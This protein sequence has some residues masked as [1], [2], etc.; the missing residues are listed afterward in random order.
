MID[1]AGRAAET[2][3]AGGIGA[4]NLEALE[5]IP[6]STKGSSEIKSALHGRMIVVPDDTLPPPLRNRLH[7]D[8]DPQHPR[9]WTRRAAR[10]EV[11]TEDTDDGPVERKGVRYV[12][13]PIH[14]IAFA[15]PTSFA[16]HRVHCAAF[17]GDADSP[18][19]G[20]RGGWGGDEE[21]DDSEDLHHADLAIRQV[22]AHLLVGDEVAEVCV[23]RFFDSNRDPIALFL[24]PRMLARAVTLQLEG[25]EDEDERAAFFDLVQD[26]LDDILSAGHCYRGDDD[27][28]PIPS[29]YR[30]LHA[31][32][33]VSDRLRD[34]KSN[35]FSIA[36]CVELLADEQAA[37]ETA[38]FAMQFADQSERVARFVAAMLARCGLS[39][40]PWEDGDSGE[41]GD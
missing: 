27:E 4:A 13:E 30:F 26:V 38:E 5:P 11:T 37:A 17:H 35:L 19:L 34:V 20:G 22:A 15:K 3:V 18:P 33:V 28:I 32:C 9:Q 31:Y 25:L 23:R 36:G 10:E 12:M 1:K 2:A 6:L 29:E 14:I 7:K 8:Y 39:V 41:E 24:L 21:E 40:S 16:N